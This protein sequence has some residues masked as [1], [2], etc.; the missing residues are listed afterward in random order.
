[1]TVAAEH[2]ARAEDARLGP[3]PGRGAGR[4]A[5]RP[6][7]PRPGAFRDRYP[8]ELSGGQQQRVGVARGAGR[9]PARAADGRAVRRGRPDHPRPPPGR[10]DPAPARAAQDDRLRHA[11][12]RRGDQARRPDR[13]AARARADRAVRHPGERSSPTRP[14]TSSRGFVGAGA[15]L[16]QLNL[17]R[18]ARDRPRGAAAPPRSA[19]GSEDVRPAPSAPGTTPSSSS[20]T[21]A[22]R[23]AG[24]GCASC[25]R[26]R[27]D[28]RPRAAGL[29]RLPAPR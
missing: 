24:P 23:R 20:T 19:S 4:G 10:A 7:R 14:T 21:A 9:R 11:R 2:R 5:A 18:V 12:L 13:G 26:D 6:G 8:R 16:K 1:M 3:R 22:A 29:A 25:G 17:A 28:V 27:A 15:A